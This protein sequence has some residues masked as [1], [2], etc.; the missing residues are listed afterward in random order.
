MCKHNGQR[1]SFRPGRYY[2]II[3]VVLFSFT[4]PLTGCGPSL[5]G[6]VP[7]KGQVLLDNKPI[8]DAVV[9]F[10]PKAG[11]RPAD[12][13][14]DASGNF[15]L[16]TFGHDDGAIPGD[17]IVTVSLMKMSN[18]TAAADDLSGEVG[19]GGIQEE[20]II[21]KRYAQRDSTPLT[22]KVESGMPPVVLKLTSSEE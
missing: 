12:G 4:L 19:E 9:M 22:A 18:I 17:Y 14:T 15:S 3:V 8:A 5:P 6:T 21:P 2:L 10:V 16:K 11:G 7:V 20:W 1:E 13:S